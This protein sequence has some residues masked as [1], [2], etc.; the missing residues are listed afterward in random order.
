MDRDNLDSSL[1]CHVL[2]ALTWVDRKDVTSSSNSEYV[3]CVNPVSELLDE[4]CFCML[5]SPTPSSAQLSPAIC[6]YTKKISSLCVSCCSD[7]ICI[8][9]LLGELV[10]QPRDQA[11]YVLL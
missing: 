5:P 3:D 8:A 2:A 4:S 6:L 11:Q 1:V 7:A 10:N 9:S